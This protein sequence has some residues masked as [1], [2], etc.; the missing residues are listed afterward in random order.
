MVRHGRRKAPSGEIPRG[1]DKEQVWTKNPLELPYLTTLLLLDHNSSVVR[2]LEL[3]HVVT[4]P[5]KGVDP[6]AFTALHLYCA[7]F[8]INH[9]HIV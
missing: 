1:S 4:L 7:S 2:L 3:S 9:Y 5:F 6:C 8:W